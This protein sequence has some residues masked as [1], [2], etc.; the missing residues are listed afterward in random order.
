MHD[1]PGDGNEHSG[2]FME[3]PPRRSSNTAGEEVHES[4]EEKLSKYQKRQ[5]DIINK[6]SRFSRKNMMFKENQDQP[7]SGSGLNETYYKE[8]EPA[9]PLSNLAAQ[10]SQTSQQSQLPE[11]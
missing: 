9:H 1:T 5:I 10:N 8:R 6:T 7:A 3:G 11:P 2:D 4:Y